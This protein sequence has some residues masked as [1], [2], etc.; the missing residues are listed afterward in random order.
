MIHVGFTGTRRGM[1]FEQKHNVRVLLLA[2]RSAPCEPLRCNHRL[3]AHHGDCIGADAEFHAIARELGCFIVGHPPTDDTRRAFCG[4]D[5]TRT[6]L[7]FAHRNAHIVSGSHYMLGAPAEDE[8]RLHGGTWSTIRLT[9]KR[10]TPIATVMPSG[11]LLDRWLDILPMET[12]VFRA[13]AR[14]EVAP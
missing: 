12:M 14:T 4:F 3:I 11:R 9:R 2:L 1:T 6:P 7:H 10:G 8:E 13:A 5:E